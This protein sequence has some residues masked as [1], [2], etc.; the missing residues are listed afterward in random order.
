MLP[1]QKVLRL[2]DAA[3]RFF[4][5]TGMLRS[6]WA[7]E[8][9][10]REG[11]PLPWLSSPAIHYLD[12]LDL[13]GARV[14]EFGSGNSTLFWKKKCANGQIKHYH[15]IE[16]D[17]TYHAKMSAKDGFYRDKVVMTDEP[18][19]YFHEVPY[20]LATN[21]TKN[22]QL[23]TPFDL[24]IVDGPIGLR[25]REL[26][27]A[28]HFTCSEGLIVVDDSNWIEA[29]VKDVCAERSLARVDF[30]GFSPSVSYTKVTSLLFRNI[31]WLVGSRLSTPAGGMTQF[32]GMS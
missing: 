5:R 17:K 19:K 4:F 21:G 28:V 13:R 26:D 24:T 20:S 22:I 30:A 8:S 12:S 9:V 27:A 10:D 23:F 18:R 3:R 1:H 29:K 16:Y 32:P 25:E 11:N 31:G 7:E 14:L 2:A 6:I 15:G